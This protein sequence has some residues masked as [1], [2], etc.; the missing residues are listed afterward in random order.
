MESGHW[1]T[2]ITK[3]EPNKILLRGYRLDE[4]IGRI[5]YGEAVYLTLKGELPPRHEGKLIEAILVSVIDHGATPPSALAART[6]AS[7][8]AGLSAA[9]AG[10]ILAISHYHGGAI[11]EC[12]AVLR[13]AVNHRR[14]QGTSVAEAATWVVEEHTRARKRLP[15]FGHR[16]HTQ[17]PRTTRLFDLAAQWGI[18][19]EF[20]QM[21][22]AIEQAMKERLGKPLPINADGAIAALL[23]EMDFD[24]M[25]ADA[26]FM[27]ARVPGLVAHIHEE[28]TRQKPMRRIH[29]TDIEYDGPAERA[30]ERTE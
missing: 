17:D 29:L 26:F 18:A 15:G 23:C 4:L 7:T 28:K 11:G 5:S 27:M 6:I 21:A 22:R 3:V 2:A 9:V 12:M 10:G 25:V 1:K 30:L 8:G 14:Q 20:V 16:L 19:G 13:E 24:P